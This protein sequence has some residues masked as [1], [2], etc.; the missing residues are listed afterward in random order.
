MKKILSF[1]IVIFII[2]LAVTSCR[3]YEDGPNISFRT[4]KARVTNNWKVESVLLNGNDVSSD[5]LWT[6][7]KHYLYRDGKYIITIINPVSLEARNL[8]GNWKLYDE[9][10][11]IEMTTKNYAGNIDSTNYYDILKLRN[12]EFWIRKDDNTLELH[13]APFE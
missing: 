10:R 7:Q 3:K 2:S 12:D 8:Q 4:K 11:K 1:F 5:P 13:F 9:D 6:K